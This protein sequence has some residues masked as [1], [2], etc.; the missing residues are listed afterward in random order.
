MRIDDTVGRNVDRHL[1]GVV[2]VFNTSPEQVA[3]QVPGLAGRW[4][5]SPVQAGGADPVVKGATWD[6]GTSTLT[7]P[8]RT[9][10]VFVQR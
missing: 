6:A 2:V 3:Q 9:A 1:R 5:L 8:G 10:A 7:V 4:T